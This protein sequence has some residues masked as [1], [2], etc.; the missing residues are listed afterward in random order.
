VHEHGVLPHAYHARAA[1]V[2]LDGPDEVGLTGHLGG[3]CRPRCRLDDLGRVL[4]VAVRARLSRSCR[5]HNS[6]VSAP[7]TSLGGRCSRDL[8]PL[9]SGIMEVTRW[10][11][12]TWVSEHP[13]GWHPCGCF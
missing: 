5:W 12:F 7:A 11:A 13:C 4:A 3:V 2:L 1:D 8:P 10:V 6:W 9:F